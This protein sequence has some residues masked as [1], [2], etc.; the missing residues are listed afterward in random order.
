M[1]FSPGLEPSRRPGEVE[2]CELLC[3]SLLQLLTVRF[4]SEPGLPLSKDT[5]FTTLLKHNVTVGFG[6]E[7]PWEGRSQRFELA[8]AVINDDGLIS[9]EEAIAIGS[10]NLEKLLGLE[11]KTQGDLVAYRGGHAFEMTSKVV[12]VISESSAHVDVFFL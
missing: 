12:A 10:S 9:D 4:C 5:T 2:G 6:I 8:W 7:A 11:V 1:S 3:L